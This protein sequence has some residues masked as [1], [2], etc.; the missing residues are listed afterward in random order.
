MRRRPDSG[1]GQPGRHEYRTVARDGIRLIRAPNEAGFA[2]V[3]GPAVGVADGGADWAGGVAAPL[4]AAVGGDAVPESPPPHPATATA[5][6]A[7]VIKRLTCITTRLQL[8]A[9]AS[10]GSSM[11]VDIRYGARKRLYPGISH[12]TGDRDQ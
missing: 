3:R 9:R 5:A 4:V 6:A 12:G 10:A 1:T 2:V 8:A 7:N 11:L